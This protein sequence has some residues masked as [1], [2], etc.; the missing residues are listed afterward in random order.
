M[1][2]LKKYWLNI[3][4]WFLDKKMRRVRLEAAEIIVEKY[5]QM[6]EVFINA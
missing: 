5:K 4:L 3:R 2:F 1:K 6:T